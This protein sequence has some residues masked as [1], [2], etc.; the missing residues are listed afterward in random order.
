[1]DRS[2][3]ILGQRIVRSET[4]YCVVYSEPHIYQSRT[5]NS[6]F[7]IAHRESALWSEIHQKVVEHRQPNLRCTQITRAHASWFGG[8]P[9]IR[10]AGYS[11]DVG[12]TVTKAWKYWHFRDLNH[13]NA[14]KKCKIKRDAREKNRDV[15]LRVSTIWNSESVCQ[16]DVTR[17]KAEKSSFPVN[18]SRKWISNKYNGI[19]WSDGIR[20]ATSKKN[21]SSH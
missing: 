3:L 4:A 6:L 1:M 13:V 8:A 7:A 12:I 15:K 2:I 11:R 10:I 18:D 21:L 5:E 16:T 19:Q 14:Q 20:N 9:D 17:F